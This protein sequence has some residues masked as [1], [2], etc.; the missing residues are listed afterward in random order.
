[1]ATREEINRRIENYAAAVRKRDAQAVSDL[2]AERFDHVVHGAGS[3]PKN[4]WNTKK[5]SD[6]EGIRAIYEDFFS[7]VEE[8]E[9]AYTDR[10][11]DVEENAAA[12]VV[13]V[14]GGGLRMENALQLK[15]NDHGKIVFFYNWY[16]EAVRSVPD[17]QS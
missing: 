7:G 10:V 1:M 4:P 15:W 16:G 11:I 12:L 3:D 2:F 5:E 6:R 8:M 17:P 9:V 13:R 14:H